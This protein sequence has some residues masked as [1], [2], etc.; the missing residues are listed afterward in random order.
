MEEFCLE[1]KNE[2]DGKG[3]EL[4]EKEIEAAIRDK[5][6][7]KAVLVL[8]QQNFE[9]ALEQKQEQNSGNCAETCI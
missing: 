4:L 9:S 6:I 7:G 5:K 2:E 8:Y 3:P 1:S